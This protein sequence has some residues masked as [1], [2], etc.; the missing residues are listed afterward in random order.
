M[1]R[2]KGRLTKGRELPDTTLRRFATLVPTWSP[3]VL[4]H[5]WS[6]PG[7]YL[8]SVAAVRVAW[9]AAPRGACGEPSKEQAG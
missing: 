2:R 1:W 9:V 3:L 7:P 5:P 4:V 8:V 6:T